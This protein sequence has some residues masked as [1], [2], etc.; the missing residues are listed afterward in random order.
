MTKNEAKEL[1]GTVTELA[2]CL[3]ITRQY[4]YKWPDPLKLSQQDRVIGA[5]MR[6]A[7]EKD[8]AVTHLLGRGG[9]E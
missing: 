1:F 5:Y 8:P 2:K 3:G 9:N 7:E 6:I 4:F